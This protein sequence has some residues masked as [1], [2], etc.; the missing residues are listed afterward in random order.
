MKQL[1]LT[2]PKPLLEKAEHYA[3]TYGFRNVQELAT[4]ALREKMFS[5]EFDEEF[6]EKEIELIDNLIEVSVSKRKVASE[7]ELRK[8]LA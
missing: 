7:Q 1:S 5:D 6:T 3:K 8:A 4:E 2:L